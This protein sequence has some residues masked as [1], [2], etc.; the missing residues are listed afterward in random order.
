MQKKMEQIT[1]F[2]TADDGAYHNFLRGHGIDSIKKYLNAG[3][4]VKHMKDD[5]DKQ[6]IFILFEREVENV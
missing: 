3:W 2:K 4:L 6:E 5:K 1:V